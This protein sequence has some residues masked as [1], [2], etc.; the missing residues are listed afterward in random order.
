MLQLV[1]SYMTIRARSRFSVRS[2]GVNI[3]I[4][5]NRHPTMPQ[6][7][8]RMPMGFGHWS[9]L[10]PKA[11][12]KSVIAN[13]Y[14]CT[15]GSVFLGRAGLSMVDGRMG[16]QYVDGGYSSG[17]HDYGEQDVL[18]QAGLTE[19]MFD[20]LDDD[21]KAHPTHLA[22]SLAEFNAILGIIIVH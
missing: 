17:K 18:G 9:H 6:R 15:K 11:R 7:R 20:W 3:W 19:A 16:T 1:S 21:E 2:Q 22:Q 13:P 5:P 8:S 12:P 14:S 10:E 4:P